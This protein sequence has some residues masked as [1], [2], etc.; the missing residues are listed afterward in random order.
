MTKFNPIECSEFRSSNP[1]FPDVP[2]PRPQC[3]LLLVSS[4]GG[5]PL[6]VTE[7]TT[8]SDIRKGK[9]DELVEI[10]KAKQVVDLSFPLPSRNA[11]YQFEIHVT[12]KARV[13][14]PITFYPA[15][16]DNIVLNS[17]LN[18]LGNSMRACTTNFALRDY[19]AAGEELSSN[20]SES[21]EYVD[22]DVGF[23][24]KIQR[25]T[26]EPYGNEAKEHVRK[27]AAAELQKERN[28]KGSEVFKGTDAETAIWA[29]VVDGVIDPEEALRRINADQQGHY[30]QKLDNLQ[31]FLE[32]LS[33]MREKDAVTDEQ[34]QALMQSF[35][36]A[37]NVVSADTPPPAKQ[38]ASENS[39]EDNEADWEE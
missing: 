8:P 16:T 27:L 4:R 12:V 6:Q 38:L 24:F 17:V 10:S 14:D 25:I 33:T 20:H 21:P 5:E 22:Q 30:D 15:Y 9:Y 26:C 18:T 35:L 39:T 31:K 28:D 23:G 19:L 37:Q 7:R 3:F 13:T 29:Q 32:V 36:F 1:F 2:R 11:P 34:Y